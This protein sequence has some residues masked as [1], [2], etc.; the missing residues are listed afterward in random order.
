[1]KSFGFTQKK[2]PTQATT[3]SFLNMLMVVEK[4]V[5]KLVTVDPAPSGRNKK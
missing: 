2:P 5:V 1:L 3:M 4:K